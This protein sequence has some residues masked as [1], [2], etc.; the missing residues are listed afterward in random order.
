VARGRADEG[1]DPV[2]DARRR[3]PRGHDEHRDDDHRGFAAEP[4]EGFLRIQDARERQ[5]HEYQH[6][7][8][9]GDG[10]RP[11]SAASDGS[12]IMGMN[13]PDAAPLPLIRPP[14]EGCREPSGG[15]TVESRTHQ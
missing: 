5:R 8:D 10:I 7:G 1:A 15:R 4:G 14:G 13:A 2:G 11:E 9:V 6:G 12:Y 3:E